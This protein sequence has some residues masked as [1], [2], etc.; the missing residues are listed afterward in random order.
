MTIIKTRLGRVWATSLVVV[1]ASLACVPYAADAATS[2]SN[3]TVSSAVSSTI[4]MTSGGTVNINTLPTSTGVQTTSSDSVSVSTNNSAGYS[5]QLAETSSAT[6]LTSGSNTIAATG[7]TYASPAALT[8]NKW[9]Y[10]VDGVGN[11]GAGPTNAVSNASIG[12]LTYAAVPA[13]GSPQQLKSTATTATNDITNVW[14]SVATNTSQPSGTYTNSV[15]YTA[16][17]N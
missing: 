7:G 9:G 12:S 14:Y 2:N 6:A 10:R 5:L 13:T 17:T 3:T 15:T 8:A 1:V 4:S 16:T 11:F